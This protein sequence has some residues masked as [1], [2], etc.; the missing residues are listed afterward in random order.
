MEFNYFMPTK[1][2]A[3]DDCINKN[4]GVLKAFGKKAMIVTGK[5]SAKVNGSLDDV[6]KALK[7]NGQEYCIF[8]K[9]MSNPTIAISYEGAEFAKSEKVNFTIAIGGGSPMD[10]AKAMALLASQDINE[11]DLFKGNYKDCV[12]PLVLIPTTAGTGSEV[13]QYSILT[14]DRLETKTSIASP[15]LFPKAT[16]LDGKYMMGLGLATTINTTIDALSHALEGMLS[17]RA[18][19]MSDCL[20]TKSAGLIAEAIPELKSGNISKET[21][22]KLLYASTLAGMVI[23]NTG[24]T[25]VHAMGYSLTYFKDID[26]GRANGLLLGETLQ[27]IETKNKDIVKKL[28]TPMGLSNAKELTDI[29]YELF[30]EKEDI[31]EEELVKYTSIA[32]KSGNITNGQVPP[33]EET[34]L[35]IYKKVFLK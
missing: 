13:T 4:A 24:T 10:A 26:H 14:N 33:D 15:L 21:R 35:N 31:T 29:L 25:S 17:K 9:V 6:I 27:F 5:H 18:G 23:A 19:V 22:D 7:S 11:E 2:Y 1:I 3:G 12:M 20:A 8:D 16:F 30:G 32:K 34:I 28:L